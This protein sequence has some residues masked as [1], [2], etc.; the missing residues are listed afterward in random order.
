[1]SEVTFNGLVLLGAPGRVMTPRSASEQLVAEAGARLSGR[2]ARVADVGT[3]GGAIAVAIASA[4]PD[5]EVWATD[6]SRC[7]VLLA[8]ANVRL[9]GLEDRVSVRHCDLLEDVPAP[10]DLIV[11]NLPYLPDSTAAEHPDLLVEPFD[12]VFAPG[13]GL[14]P[15]R[16]LVDAARRWLA[17]DGELLLQLHRRLL[18]ATRAELPDLATA[19]DV[20]PSTSEGGVALGEALAAAAA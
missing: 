15:Y 3:G 6:T 16:Q 19:F 18:A 10:V 2:R 13:D 5:A 7:A 14:G 17:D 20:S 12:S 11:A 8:R 4:C 9:H 1:M